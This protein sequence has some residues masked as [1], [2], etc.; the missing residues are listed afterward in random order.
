MQYNE[1]VTAWQGVGT[2]SNDTYASGISLTAGWQAHLQT[3]WQAML[4]GSYSLATIAARRCTPKPS[5]VIKAQ[6]VPFTVQ[7]SRNSNG[8][9]QQVCPCIFLIPPMGTKSGGKTF[10]PC[11]GQNDLLNKQ[12][13]SGYHTAIQNYSTAAKAGFS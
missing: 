5:V 6:Y 13:A 3:L 11:G 1:C 10:L 4:P 8:C 9:A 12:Y 7:G 2:N